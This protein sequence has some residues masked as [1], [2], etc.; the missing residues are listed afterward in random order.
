[1]ANG[2]RPD[3]IH[4]ESRPQK[5]GSDSDLNTGDQAAGG[6]SVFGDLDKSVDSG[7][8]IGTVPGNAQRK[9]FR[10]TQG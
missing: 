6:P 4:T 8:P 9:P 1:M 7:N 3:P 10:I 5:Q 2:G